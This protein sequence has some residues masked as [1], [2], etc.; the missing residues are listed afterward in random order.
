[1]SDTILNP[2]L[3]QP[4]I[5]NFSGVEINSPY[6]LQVTLER[7]RLFATIRLYND[8]P[9][10]YIVSAEQETLVAETL[11]SLARIRSTCYPHALFVLSGDYRSLAND[12]LDVLKLRIAL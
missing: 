5:I 8:H 4:R 11:E 1:M 6:L 10:V 2:L 12:D 7:S 9:F 3:S